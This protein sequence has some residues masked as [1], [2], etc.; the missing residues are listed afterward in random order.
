M[1]ISD[2]PHDSTDIT[3]ELGSSPSYSGGLGFGPGFRQCILLGVFRN[4]IQSFQSN[5]RLLLQIMT[6]VFSRSVQLLLN[7][8]L[9]QAA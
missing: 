4:S 1:S 7:A 9:T 6:K 8:N 2:K 3:A 5:S